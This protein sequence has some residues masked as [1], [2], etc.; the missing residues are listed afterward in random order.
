MEKKGKQTK[1]GILEEIEPHDKKIMKEILTTLRKRSAKSLKLAKKQVVTMNIKSIEAR[2]ALEFYASNWDDVTHPGILSLTCEAVGGEPKFAVPMQVIMLLLTGAIDLHDDI[3]DQSEIKNG[4]PTVFG[5]FGKDIALLLGDALLLRG[6]LMLHRYGRSFPSKTVERVMS[7]VE[8]R[9]FEFGNA[10]LSEIGL[11]RQFEIS[12]EEY[13]KVL[14]QKGT[15]IELHACLGAIVGGGSKA[16][17]E[18]IER[19][20][21]ILGTLIAIREEFIDIF[22]FEELRNRIKERRLPLPILYAL[23]N[24]QVKESILSLETSSK[25]AKESF[26]RIVD[27]VFLNENVR[28]LIEMMYR[29]SKKGIRSLRRLSLKSQARDNL[30]MLIYGALEDL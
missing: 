29:L 19:Y 25:R 26:D 13:L 11:D 3:I 17:I 8:D 9:F 6:L 16:D 24:P 7:T 27:L 2:K 14:E 10:H 21:K 18:A 23:S 30:E 12:P 28:R 22:E 20:G 15:T 5:K 4:R 1:N